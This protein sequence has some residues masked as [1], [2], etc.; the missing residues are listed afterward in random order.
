MEQGISPEQMG[1]G[2]DSSCSGACTL[3]CSAEPLNS[4]AIAS[5]S[6]SQL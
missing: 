2:Q 1:S 6:S 4:S 5:Q 3:G